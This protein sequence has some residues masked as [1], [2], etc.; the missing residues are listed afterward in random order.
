M[1]LNTVDND[2]AGD[3]DRLS[4]APPPSGPNTFQSSLPEG[5]DW[6][7][8]VDRIQSGT[9]D[10]MEELY[11]LFS[12]G[13]RFYLCRQLGPQEL[14][15]KVHD[16]FLIVVEAIQRGELRDPERLMGFVR[17]IV[18]RQVASY[19][20]VAVQSRRDVA[21]LEAGGVVV[22]ANR[23]PEEKAIGR[24]NAL[25]MLDILH[26]MSS[27]DR[28]ILTR[29]YLHEQSQDQ[30]CTEMELTDTQFRLLKSRAKARFGE[31]GRKKL[32]NKS[33]STF[34]VRTFGRAGH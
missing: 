34:S 16:T 21:D 26:K 29:F 9:S 15:D 17:T 7:R 1:I 22:D 11:Q 13:V 25:I 5:P 6:H 19:I 2:L 31:L 8:L 3:D 24:E 20:D 14:D 23:N 27:R 28:E 33:V 10:G 4:A 12:R 18:R 30:I 32:K